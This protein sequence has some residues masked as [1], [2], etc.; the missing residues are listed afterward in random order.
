MMVRGPEEYNP[1]RL[2]GRLALQYWCDASLKIE[3]DDLRY[4]EKHQ[5]AGLLRSESVAELRRLIAQHAESVGRP[6][7]KLVI[8]PSDYPGS[9]KFM[10]Q[11]YLD[12]MALMAKYGVPTYLIIFTMNPRW[13]EVLHALEVSNIGDFRQ[14]SEFRPDII[15]RVFWIKYRAFLL[16]SSPGTGSSTTC[17]CRRTILFC[18]CGTTPILMCSCATATRL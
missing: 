18:P 4:I 10:H 16:R 3:Y 12:T 13:P 6:V 1:I 5:Q 9:P 17:G 8:L 15:M 2:S 14:T 7:G 11:Q